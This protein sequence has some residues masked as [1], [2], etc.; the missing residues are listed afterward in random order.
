[1]EEIRWA[2]AAHRS[3]IFVAS[4]KGLIVWDMSAASAPDEAHIA[5]RMPKALLFK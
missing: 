4:A 2:M 1:V 3:M 5:A